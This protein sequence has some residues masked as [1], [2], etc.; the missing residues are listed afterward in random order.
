MKDLRLMY[1]SDVLSI[2]EV[3]EVANVSPRRLRIESDADVRGVLRVLMNGAI[4]PSFV[5]EGTRYIVA[6]IPSQMQNVLLADILVELV[7]TSFSGEAAETTVKFEIGR[8]PTAV[9]GIQKLVQQVVRV[10]LT[11]LG[12]DVF[13]PNVGGDIITA[14][15]AGPDLNSQG[16]VLTAAHQAVSTTQTTIIEEQSRGTV[17]PD[18]EKLESLEILSSS[19]LAGQ[20]TLLL[21]IRVLSVAGESASVPIAV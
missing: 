16:A 10:L 20:A 21:D 11:T 1:L 13:S 17:L 4:S 9:A 15:A 19:V 18:D 7:G 5:K 2:V 3:T 12:R 14:M 6:V 8:F